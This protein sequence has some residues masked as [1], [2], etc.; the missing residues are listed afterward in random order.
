MTSFQQ[1][2]DIV[3]KLRGP[4]GCPWDKEQTHKSLTPYA[5]E[6]AYELEE[7]IEKG[8]IENMK[9]ELGDLLFQTVLHS[10]IASETQQFD[11]DDVISH[12]NHKM[13]SRHPHVFSDTLVKDSDEVVQN[14]EQIK[15][16]EKPKDIF[17][18]PQTF[19]ALLRSHKIGKRTKKMDFDWDTPKEV[20]KK[21]KEEITELEEAM[22]NKD[23]SHIEEEMGDIL[24]TAAQVARHLNLDSEKTLRLANEKFVKRFQKMLK[25]EP[26]FESLPRAEKEKLWQQIK[27]S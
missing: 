22:A 2:I 19:P 10:Q 14:W 16:Q 7:A 3:K 25:K 12:L 21:L 6:E 8:D 15:A 5:I 27:K 18:I 4:Q 11:V 23:P 13:T 9:E 24:F 1:L 17:D 26:Q 20:L